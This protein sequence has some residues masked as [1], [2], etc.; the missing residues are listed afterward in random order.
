[1]DYPVVQVF[2]FHPGASPDVTA[3]TVTAPLERRLGQIPGLQ[4]MASSSSGGASVITLRF[5]LEV[6][7]AVAE[8]EVQAAIQT[9]ASL[10]PAD[11]PS[12]P[13]YRK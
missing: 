11:L 8:Q 2:T 10:L 7:M 3:R 13:I 1:V 6:G 4:Q 12:P 5:A 9:A